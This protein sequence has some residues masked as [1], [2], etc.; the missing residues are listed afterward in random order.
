MNTFTAAFLTFVPLI[1]AHVFS[2]LPKEEHF[3]FSIFLFVFFSKHFISNR[4]KKFE[5]LDVF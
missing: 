3:Y 2:P 1:K 4:R 5:Y